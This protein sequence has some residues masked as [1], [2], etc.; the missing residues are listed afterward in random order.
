[1]EDPTPRSQKEAKNI[2]KQITV[3]KDEARAQNCAVYKSLDRIKNESN[4][5]HAVSFILMV[6]TN[7]FST[8]HELTTSRNVRSVQAA[9]EVV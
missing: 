3:L 5:W 8:D 4:V 2:L 9:Q 1:M 6:A 7:L